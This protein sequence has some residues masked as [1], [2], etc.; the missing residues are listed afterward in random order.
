MLM[1]HPRS[2]GTQTAVRAF[3][4]THCP[5]LSQSW[6]VSV[7]NFY[8]SEELEINKTNL[9]AP[10]SSLQSSQMTTVWVLHQ[11]S[12]LTLLFDEPVSHKP[13]G[14]PLFSQQ[15]SAEFSGSVRSTS[16]FSAKQ[17]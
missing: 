15:S 6:I 11:S 1:G 3:E 14:L 17:P 9:L 10:V 2:Q 12:V 13:L 8:K 5:H 7:L 16:G 4:N